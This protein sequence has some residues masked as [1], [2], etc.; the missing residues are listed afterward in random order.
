MRVAF[1]SPPSVRF[2]ALAC[3]ILLV[4]A[5]WEDTEGLFNPG[6]DSLVARSE[7]QMTRHLRD[8]LNDDDLLAIR[9]EPEAGARRVA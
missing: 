7:A 2:E 4:S 9:D 6:H 3:G 1:S 5:S 8:V